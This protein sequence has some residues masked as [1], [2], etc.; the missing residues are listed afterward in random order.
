MKYLNKLG[1]VVV[2]GFLLSATAQSATLSVTSLG[3]SGP[4]T[5]RQAITDAAPGDSIILSTAGSIKLFSTLVIDKMLSIR[6]PKNVSVSLEASGNGFGQFTVNAGIL[7]M[8]GFTV[9]KGA[10]WGGSGASVGGGLFVAS[11]AWVSLDRMTFEG[12]EAINGGAVYNEGSL[13]V[14]NSTFSNNSALDPGFGCDGGGAGAAIGNQGYLL[15]RNATFA[16]NHSSCAAVLYQVGAT[17]VTLM[18]NTLMTNQDGNGGIGGGD[19]CLILSGSVVSMGHNM[20]DDTGI[21]CNLVGAGDQVVTDTLIGPLGNYGGA[22]QTHALLSG[23]P[24]I[25]AGDDASAPSI[26][27]RGIARPS[28]A[29]SDIGAYEFLV[30][31]GPPAIQ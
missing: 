28:G 1:V 22:T 10:N 11:G 26:D 16:N 3:D 23:S 25:D 9:A 12:N 21:G 2:G 27:Q 19:F 29:A 6:A 20:Q 7:K 30:R 31:V 5:L 4:G 18:A 14:L 15:I 8:T 13:I 24:A 17:A